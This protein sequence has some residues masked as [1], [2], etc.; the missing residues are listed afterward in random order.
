MKRRLT[1]MFGACATIAL[2]ALASACGES[3]KSAQ[4]TTST[5]TSA[6]TGKPIVIGVANSL[7]GALAPFETAINS[8]MEIAA[9]QINAA[10]GVKGRPIR[11]IHVDAK[12]DANLSAT[13]TLD[14]IEK[15]A[16]V[17]V[18][19]CDA[20]FGAP[21]ARAANEKGV[22]AITCAG[23]PGLGAQTIGPLTFNTAPGSATEGAIIA[24][25]AYETK[26]WR[27]A[28]VV[29]D[30]ILEY[31][32]VVC[33]AFKTRWHELGGEIVGEDTFL[34]S[35]PSI[36]PQVTR[37]TNASKPD[38]LLLS[39]FPGGS[40][41]IKQIRARYDGPMMLTQ[42][43]AGTFWL[44]ATPHLSDAWAPASG[45]SYGDDPRPEMNAFFAAYKKKTG[46]AALVDT[47]PI[48]G[49]SLVQTIARGVELAGTTD[50]VKLGAALDTFKDVPLLAGPTTYTPNCHV[51]VGRAMLIIQY[52]DGKPSSTGKVVKPKQVPRY[53]C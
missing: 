23:G 7:T 24:E 22:L 44:K 16:D 27:R 14:V 36:S 12:S 39:S 26:A 15:G 10:G 5:P 48:L 41:A 3:N 37:L 30:Q 25:Y 47:Y 11:F 51:P 35:D 33:K 34:Q 21:G 1:L 50:G 17:V 6:A 8:G 42:A 13:A 49:Y 40:P 28:Y 31:S 4:S 38:V 20:D 43:F 53:P 29:C 52:Q 32:K 18:P 46:K 45:S 2:V 9:D 19:I